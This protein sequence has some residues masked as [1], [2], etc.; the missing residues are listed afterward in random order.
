MLLYLSPGACSLSPHIVLFEA[1]VSFKTEK[2]VL[3]TH[4]TE[5][6]AD[7]YGVNA[8]GYVPLLELDDGRRLTEGPA[9]VQWIADQAPSKKLAPPN[10][11]FE[12]AKL[13]EWL[14]F[15]GTELHKQFWAL[16]DK[17]AT[18]DNKQMQRGKIGKRLAYVEECLLEGAFLMGADF[19]VADAYLFTVT[20]WA[21]HLRIEAANAPKLRAWYDR[22][23][24]RPKV[25]AALD[26]EGIRA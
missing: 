23:A 9:I 21:R 13:Q 7:Y 12:R 25:K 4:K 3:S 1:G 18:E 19:T 8:N 14:S 24:A 15:I 10:G 20:R 16:F 22:V 11:T 17:S 5:H 26:A 2:V 6:D